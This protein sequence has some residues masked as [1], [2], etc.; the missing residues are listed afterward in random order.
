MQYFLIYPCTLVQFM[1]AYLK[2]CH[3]FDSSRKSREI[4]CLTISGD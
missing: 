2:L 4:N 3:D 1:C